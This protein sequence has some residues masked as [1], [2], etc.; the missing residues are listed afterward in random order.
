MRTEDERPRTDRAETS[1]LDMYDEILVETELIWSISPVLSGVLCEF[2]VGVRSLH[3]LRL[4]SLKLVFN[5]STN[6]L[7]INKL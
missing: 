5:H 2:T 7:L 6:F 4:E 3:T 1:L